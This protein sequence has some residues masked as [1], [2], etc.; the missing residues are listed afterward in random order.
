MS[1]HTFVG[2]AG[3]SVAIGWDRPLETF[4]VQVSRP[5]PEDPGERDTFVWKGLA[6]GELSTAA[7][8]IAIA[9]PHAALPTDL[10]T[11][12]ET[13]RLQTLGSFDGPAQAAMKRQRFDRDL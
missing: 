2:P 13:D 10:G 7:A 6:P 1:R 11:T 8:A 9:T 12:L 3:V 4:Y 5:D